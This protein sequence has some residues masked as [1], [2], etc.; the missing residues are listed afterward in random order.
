[1]A[2]AREYCAGHFDTWNDDITTF[3]GLYYWS[4]GV[5]RI[6]TR[7]SPHSS[8]LCSTAFLRGTNVALGLAAVAAA[9]YCIRSAHGRIERPGTL[10]T[11]VWVIA[12]LP[13]LFFFT[14][15]Y[16]TDAGSLACVLACYGAGLHAVP[17]WRRARVGADD[18]VVPSGKRDAPQPPHAASDP[19]GEAMGGSL[20]ADSAA[21]PVRADAAS[22][23][24]SVQPYPASMVAVAGVRIVV[25]RHQAGAVAGLFVVGVGGR[26]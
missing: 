24:V 26:G 21:D 15:L 1:M 10:T 7:L 20:P 9:E 19:P 12:T 25:A 2:Q 13:V 6:W 11:H 16:Y 3:P 23:L 18:D 5:F 14:H 4:A 8:A 17:E 22:L